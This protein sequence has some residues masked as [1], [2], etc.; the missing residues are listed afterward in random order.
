MGCSSMAGSM[1]ESPWPSCNPY[2]T[3]DKSKQKF[4]DTPL[5]GR[6]V[7]FSKRPI[8]NRCYLLWVDSPYIAISKSDEK[9]SAENRGC[10]STCIIKL[11]TTFLN[12]YFIWFQ[13]FPKAVLLILKNPVFIFISLAGCTE[14]MAT[15]GFATFLPKFIQNQ[16]SKTASVAA[17]I[18]GRCFLE[19]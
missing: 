18:A 10:P 7:I 6:Y 15:G 17:F 16:F 3:L 11:V 19:C 1:S 9:L 4:R 8:T 13:D 2:A 14:G 5:K 12:Y